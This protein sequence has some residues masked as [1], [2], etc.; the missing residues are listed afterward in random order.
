MVFHEVQARLE[1]ASGRLLVEERRQLGLDHA[2]RGRRQA[3]FDIFMAEVTMPDDGRVL[4]DIHLLKSKVNDVLDH[5]VHDLRIDHLEIDPAMDF[6]WD[7]SGDEMFN[8][9]KATP[10]PVVGR[11]SDDLEFVEAM[12]PDRTQAPTI[13]FVHLAPLLRY[14]AQKVGR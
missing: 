5:V 14:I 9:H 2:E 7:I 1:A 10:E 3:R 4:I 11:L 13:M 6:Y 12:E 8:V